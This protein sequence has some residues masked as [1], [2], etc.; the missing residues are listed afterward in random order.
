MEDFVFITNGFLQIK[1]KILWAKPPYK[2]ICKATL[3]LSFGFGFLDYLYR[4][5]FVLYHK[6]RMIYKQS[7]ELED[8]RGVLLSEARDLIIKA[9]FEC[10]SRSS[11]FKK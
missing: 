8:E 9:F 4:L 5:L 10:Y 11:S 3:I 2:A 1:L 6:I 7:Q